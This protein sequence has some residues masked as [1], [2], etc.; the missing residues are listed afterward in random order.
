MHD[1]RAFPIHDSAEG[2]PRKASTFLGLSLKNFKISYG[3]HVFLELHNHLR[4]SLIGIKPIIK[5]VR[6]QSCEH[7]ETRPSLPGTG[8]NFV[9][10]EP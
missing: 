9:R 3:V 5:C 6:R 7:M 10:Q 4:V 8:N 2:H 1:L